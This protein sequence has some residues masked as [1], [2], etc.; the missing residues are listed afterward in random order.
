MLLG[1]ISD[2]SA[3][4]PAYSSQSRLILS[5]GGAVKLMSMSLHAEIIYVTVTNVVG[6]NKRRLCVSSSTQ[7]SKS[8]DS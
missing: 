8:F 5:R 7:Q 2:I 3:S 1:T 6:D 4:R